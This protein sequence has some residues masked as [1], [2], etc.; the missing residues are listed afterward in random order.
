MKIFPA[1]PDLSFLVVFALSSPF[2]PAPFFSRPWFL[3]N[4]ECPVD[5]LS[6][7]RREQ[8]LRSPNILLRKGGLVA[9]RSLP[10]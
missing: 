8:V 3:L 7:P 10:R 1:G 9:Q 6:G 2:L 5:P 4:P